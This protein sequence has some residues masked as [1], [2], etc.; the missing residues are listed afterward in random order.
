MIR[1]TEWIERYEVNSKGHEAKPG[2]ALREGPLPF[3]RL[4]AYGQVHSA[5]YRQL[6]AAAGPESPGIFGIFVKFLEL[7]GNRRREERGVLFNHKDKPASAQ[8][9][10]FLLGFPLEKI[11][12]AIEVLIDIGWIEVSPHTPL[13]HNTTQY[14]TT[15]ASANFPEFPAQPEKPGVFT[16]Q[17]VKDAAYLAGIT[18]EKAEQFFHHY[19][20]QGWRLGN[21]QPITDLPSAIARWRNNGYKYDKPAKAKTAAEL[22]AEQEARDAARRSST[23]H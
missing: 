23:I 8:D 12:R 6:L 11:E 18:D 4:K 21:G 3:I 16:L 20:A 5:G 14:N 17:A 9:L 1:I 22:Y 19:N 15:Q 13:Q 7:A 2:E 10:A